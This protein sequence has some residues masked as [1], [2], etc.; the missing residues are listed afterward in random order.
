MFSAFPSENKAL[1]AKIT[2]Q[3]YRGA[4]NDRLYSVE[5]LE[6]AEPEGNLVPAKPGVLSGHDGPTPVPPG[7][8]LRKMASEVNRGTP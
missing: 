4:N 3:E 5:A 8:L 6:V 7:E 1:I 2:V